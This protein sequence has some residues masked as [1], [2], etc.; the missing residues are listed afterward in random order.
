MGTAC[1]VL[2]PEVCNRALRMS[3][4][5]RPARGSSG[6]SRR[7]RGSTRA[8]VR[9]RPHKAVERDRHLA[10]SRPGHRSGTVLMAAFCASSTWP[11]APFGESSPYCAGVSLGLRRQMRTF[12]NRQSF[13]SSVARIPMRRQALPS[14]TRPYPSATATWRKSMRST[15]PRPLPRARHARGRLPAGIPGRAPGPGPAPPR[16]IATEPESDRY[17][18]GLRGDTSAASSGLHGN[19]A[20]TAAWHL[21][22]R[23]DREPPAWRK[24]GVRQKTIST[25][26]GPK[27]S[28]RAGS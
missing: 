24:R 15:R 21:P 17:W 9:R 4:V 10:A 14:S 12:G 25:R 8:S 28:L 19:S 22:N 16:L 23:R 27:P 1:T 18:A 2:Q 3:S 6:E 7:L 26:F 11:A 20:G 5:S 13:S